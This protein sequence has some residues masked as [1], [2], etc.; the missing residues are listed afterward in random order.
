MI[1]ELQRLVIHNGD[2]W[3]A[4]PTPHRQ[5]PVRLLTP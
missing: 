4:S 2:Y 1:Q 3:K 5:M